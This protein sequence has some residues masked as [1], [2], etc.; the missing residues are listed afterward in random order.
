MSRS[1]TFTLHRAS[2]A[3]WLSRMENVGKDFCCLC[4]LRFKFGDT[5][6]SQRAGYR[7]RTVKPYHKKCL[8]GTRI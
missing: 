1:K 5:V 6:T 7:G 8:D 2:H 3:Q 4:G